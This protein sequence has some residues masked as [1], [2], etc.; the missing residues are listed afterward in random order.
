MLARATVRAL[1]AVAA[2]LLLAGQSRAQTIRVPGEAPLPRFEVASV[3]PN[4]SGEGAS[5]SGNLPDGGYRGI[6]VTLRRLVLDAYEF[7]A[8]QIVGEPPWWSSAR[9]DVIARAEAKDD[10]MGARL[11][12]LLVD[13]FQLTT[14]VEQRPRPVYALRLAHGDGRLGPA[15]KPSLVDCSFGVAGQPKSGCGVRGSYGGWGGTLAGTGKTLAQIAEAL[16]DHGADRPVI[17]RTGVPGSY[18]FELKWATNPKPDS[19]EVTLVT[20]LR[21]QLG[22]TLDADTASV[23]VL[24]IDHVEQPEPD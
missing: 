5:Q 18:D 8:N 10:Q 17:D 21:E 6:N 9:F 16:G 19:D 3:K 2:M 14:H 22:L 7:Q 23:D 12:A 4:L 13:R 15:L 1:P 20:A 24:V 11:R